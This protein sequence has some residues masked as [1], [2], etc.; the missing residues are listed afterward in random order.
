[1]VDDTTLQSMVM[2][3]LVWVPNVDAAHIGVAAH[4][5]VVTLTGI[6]STFA[7]KF[8]AE[9]A[10]RRVKGVRGIAEEIVV[11]PPSA[12]K[13]ADEEIAERA[14]KILAWDVEV[15]DQELQ[16]KVEKGILTLTGIVANQ[17]QKRKAEDDIRRLS[18]VT[19]IVNLIEVRASAIDAAH[20]G[21]LHQKIE[22]AL[23]RSAELEAAHITVTV[24]GG[25]AILQGRVKSWWERGI[26]EN[27]AWAAPGIME[28]DDRIVVGG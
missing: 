1:M 15:P 11:R 2:D 6:V 27:A 14:L 17:F 16:V 13:R 22:D 10:V 18:G 20:A 7:E 4:D 23:R 28:V 24:Q 21:G 9:R 12:H 8:A 5:G 26:A 19:A 3:E 25:K